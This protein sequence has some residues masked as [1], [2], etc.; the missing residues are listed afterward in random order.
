MDSTFQEFVNSLKIFNVV[1][2]GTKYCFV[3]GE[4]VNNRTGKFLAFT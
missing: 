1:Q 2:L 4:T 3:V